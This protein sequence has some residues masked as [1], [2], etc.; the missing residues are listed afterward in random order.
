MG[1]R[2]VL[3]NMLENGHAIGGEQSGHII[4]LEHNSTGDGMMSAIAL[5]NV[6]ADEKKPL[7]ALA[8]E[9]PEFPQVLVNVTVENEAK[10]A[11]MADEELAAKK[12]EIERAMN[13]DGRVLIRASGTEPLMRIMLEGR[14]EKEILSYALEL[15]HILVRKHKGKIKA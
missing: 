3:E 12:E 6:V 15:A 10:A 2:Y 4:L 1:D 5:L 13:G 14:D 7:S 9:I 11:A 8:N